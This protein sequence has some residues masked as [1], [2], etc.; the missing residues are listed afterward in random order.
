MTEL[1]AVAL[2][3]NILQF[4]EVGIK[5]ANTA[6][7]A[8]KSADGYIKE[9]KDLLADTNRL[10][11]LLSLIHE[12]GSTQEGYRQAL[13]Y[14]GLLKA[15]RT[16]DACASELTTLLN[17]MRMRPGVARTLESLR[18]SAM[19]RFKSGE[20]RDL[21]A[22]MATARSD[23]ILV[24]TTSSHSKQSFVLTAV[25][26]LREQNGVLEA[27]TTTRLESIE[28]LIQGI[29]P[30]DANAATQMITYLD[31]LA[32]EVQ[33]V[34]RHR[35][36]LNSL[37]FPT[38]KQRQSAIMERH[39]ATFNWVFSENKTGFCEWLETGNGFFWVKGKAGSGKSTLMKYLATHD[40]TQSR[41]QVWGEGRRVVKAN[42]FFWN[43]GTSIQKSVTGL[44]QTILYQVIKICPELIDVVSNCRKDAS[45][46]AL[47]EPW[48]DKELRLAFQSLSS[49]QALSVKF[50]LFIDGLDEYT[51]GGQRY[52]GTFEELLDPLRI[53]V[54]SGSIKICVS[55]RP[56]NVFDNEFSKLKWQLQLEDL[57]RKDIR[58]YV[59]EK[60]GVDPVFQGLCKTD[61]RCSEIPD[62]IVQRAQGVF[63]W[64]F[65]VVSSLRRGLHN[66]DNYYNLV[67]RL[68]ELPDDLEAYFRH[69]LETIEDVY[70]ESTSRI[71]RT[72]IAAEQSLPLLIFH[73][74]DQELDDTDYAI[75][76]KTRSFS[77]EDQ[78]E[79]CRRSK[80]RLNA[81]CRDLLY[82]AVIAQQPGVL[83]YQVGF[84]HRTVRDFF[85]DTG[86]INDIVQQRPTQ[87]FD[88]HLS[89]CKSTLALSKFIIMDE[90][91]SERISHAFSLY[92]SIMHYARKVEETYA[93]LKRDG[94]TQMVHDDLTKT[95]EI[96]DELDRVNTDRL[97]RPNVH[98][99]NLKQSLDHGSA[100]DNFLSYAIEA[101]LSLYVE[102]SLRKQPSELGLKRGRPLLDYVLRPTIIWPQGSS[103]AEQGPVIPILKLLLDHGA[104]ANTRIDIY[105]RRTP[106]ELFIFKCYQRRGRMDPERIE[107]IGT[108]MELLIS[109]GARTKG[110][111]QPAGVHSGVELMWIVDQLGLQQHQ[112]NIIR[113]MVTERAKGQHFLRSIFS[114]VY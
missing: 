88:P 27:N 75:T 12:N 105:N 42:H 60:L 81:R 47:A 15:V 22:K 48:D 51:A 70:W 101:R 24:L 80:A 68:N 4:L 19:R 87:K 90:G 63:L 6:R 64:V 96:L 56:W 1:A 74:L 89:L 5:L 17:T 44:F 7:R 59:K 84:L 13:M 109:H 113:E 40:Q 83:K 26:E 73:F 28:R 91:F 65:L 29:S 112:V 62:I 43:A 77:T 30:S 57:T 104:N 9:D 92:N 82:V 45:D 23:L 38:I 58:D 20:I 25:R 67:S 39:Q 86:V 49:Q 93:L 95:F 103:K 54:S 34:K 79:I 35:N 32:S 106:W 66:D 53:L 110:T 21:E 50:C 94:K 107:E 10:R 14:D 41:L 97:G 98:W 114:W 37:L 16:C 108:A 61:H 33:Q 69:M 72:V 46:F 31:N 18:V 2:A 78:R 102:A 71:F 55:S 52:T 76:M 8:Y 3:G 85:M 111:F 36:L 99:T 100:Q 11:A